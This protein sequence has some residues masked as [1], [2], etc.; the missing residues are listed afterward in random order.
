MEAPLVPGRVVASGGRRDEASLTLAWADGEERQW[1]IALAAREGRQT[2]NLRTMPGAELAVLRRPDGMFAGWAG[3]DVKSDPQRPEVFSQFVYPRFR[4][5]GLGSLLEHFWWAYLDAAGCSTGYMRMEL[6][7]N[8]EL[9]ERRLASGYC[10]QVSPQELGP[11]FV[12]ACHR[13]E[14]F[15]K[16]CSR[17]IYL[18]VDVPKALAARTQTG[19]VLRID[20]LPLQIEMEPERPVA[21]HVAREERIVRF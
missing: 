13:C 9:V 2:M 11:R 17:Q 6:E 7:S 1:V 20:S 4:G 5:T 21:I 15:G 3:V 12:S 19:R 18:A 14:L 10:R 16:A 8:H